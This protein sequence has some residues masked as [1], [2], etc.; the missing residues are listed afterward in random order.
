MFEQALEASL[1]IREVVARSELMR[2]Q[3][4]LGG[5]AMD[6]SIGT[7]LDPMRK[8]DELLDWEAEELRT[9]VSSS[10]EAID[11]ALSVLR[12]MS[13]MGYEDAAET[14]RLRYVEALDV[15]DV[16]E[17]VGQSVDVVVM[18]CETAFTWCDEVGLARIKE[19][20]H[21]GVSE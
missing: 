4:G 11:E 13:V 15:P 21:A 17:R 5:R 1:R 3:I 7:A 12:G 16:A 19:A 14:L 18:M 10:R 20:G 9:A 8:V 2:E 6:S